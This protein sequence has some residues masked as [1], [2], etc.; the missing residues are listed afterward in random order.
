MVK[1]IQFELIEERG[2]SSIDLDFVKNYLRVSHNYDDDLIKMQL[3]NTMELVA[4]YIGLQINQVVVRAK[5]PKMVKEIYLPHM[6]VIDI[7]AA[8]IKSKGKDIDIKEHL[9]LE[10]EQGIVLCDEPEI[11]GNETHIIYAAGY[12]GKIPAS[13]YIKLLQLVRIQ[14]EAMPEEHIDSKM[15]HDLFHSYKRVKI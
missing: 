11:L 15:I 12:E 8:L 13:I 5:I 7:K 14:Y 2:S 9:R 4:R 10:S 1:R 3:E 6:P